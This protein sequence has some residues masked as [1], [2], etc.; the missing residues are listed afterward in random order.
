LIF[1]LHLGTTRR[2]STTIDVAAAIILSGFRSGARMPE[3][4]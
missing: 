3:G 1:S 2:L 4:G